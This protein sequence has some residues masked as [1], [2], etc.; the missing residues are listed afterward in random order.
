METINYILLSIVSYIGLFCGVL[1]AFIAPE[2]QRPGKNYFLFARKI[3]LG[4]MVMAL[5]ILAPTIYIFATSVILL[6]MMFFRN[7]NNYIV[8]LLFVPVIYLSIN[9]SFL[10]LIISTQIFLYGM[11]TG[12]LIVQQKKHLDAVKRCLRF[13]YYPLMLSLLFILPFISSYFKVG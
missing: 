1:L 11:L 13:S 8:Y 4:T 10:I 6:I 2:E 9:N 3:I 12:T 5:L 7:L